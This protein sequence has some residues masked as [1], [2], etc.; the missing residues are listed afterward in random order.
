MTRKASQNDMRP[1]DVIEHVF[2][3]VFPILL[4]LTDKPSPQ[5]PP[6]EAPDYFDMHYQFS[7]PYL[8]IPPKNSILKTIF[9][10]VAVPHFFLTCMT[11]FLEYTKLFV[12]GSGNFSADIL[13]F[14]ISTL[15]LMAVSRVSRWF[16]VKSHYDKV[17]KQVR[18]IHTELYYFDYDHVDDSS[19]KPIKK[20]VEGQTLDTRR[21][22]LKISVAFITFVWINIII[23]Y[24]TNYFT[25]PE[26]ERW[27]P[28]K[29]KTSTYRDYPYPLYYPFDISISDGYYW[30]GFFYQP[31]AFLFLMC[32][33][34]CIDCLTVNTIIHLTS[35]INILNFAISCVDRNLNKSLSFEG[36]LKITEKRILKCIKMSEKIYKCCKMLNDVCSSQLFFQQI[37]LSTVM[38]CSVY[39]VTSR[40]SSSEMIYLSSIVFSVAL[41]MFNVA[42]QNQNFTLKA[43]E[44]LSNIYE[45]NWLSY[46]VKLRRVLLCFMMRIQKPFHFTMGLGF[47]LEIG[48]FLTMVKS[49][50]SFY[51]LITQSGNHL[52]YDQN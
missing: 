39:R 2:K 7:A 48:V 16:F 52:S 44:L 25:F 42:W 29:N 27:N 18:E 43:F 5:M 11:T 14:G 32:A 24:V 6:G 46:S 35:F 10:V 45:L 34:L 17:L 8:L 47:P 1:F 36:S 49:S 23:S 50:Y 37:C 19:S 28:H 31:Y 4:L 15:H 20:Y 22:C 12:G 40:P 33:F 38:C 26:V 30:L 51:A 13:N 21:H 41:E 9:W 3:C